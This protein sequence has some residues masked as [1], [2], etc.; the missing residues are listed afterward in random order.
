M[1][2]SYDA[3]MDGLDLLD[4]FHPLDTFDGLFHQCYTDKSGKIKT[5]FIH[6]V[7]QQVKLHFTVIKG[8]M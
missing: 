3:S 4:S 8:S 6:L 1:S 7:G 2:N 5:S